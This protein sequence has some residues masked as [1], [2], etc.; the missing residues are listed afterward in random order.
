[1]QSMLKY[2]TRHNGT[3]SADPAHGEISTDGPLSGHEGHGFVGRHSHCRPRFIPLSHHEH[4]H[5][6]SSRA[7]SPESVRK[8]SAIFSKYFFLGLSTGSG[9]RSY[10]RV[11]TGIL[12]CMGK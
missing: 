7:A 12:I 6:G 4:E 3:V 1:M 11:H 8:S 2:V 9:A 5:V 10:L